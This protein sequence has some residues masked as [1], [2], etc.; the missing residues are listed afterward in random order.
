M[1]ISVILAHPDDGSFN[2][3]IAHK[4][5]PHAENLELVRK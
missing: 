3:A 2:H 5:I 1:R 4:P